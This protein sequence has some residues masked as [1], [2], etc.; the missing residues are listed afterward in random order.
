LRRLVTVVAIGVIGLVAGIFLGA[1]SSWMPEPVRSALIEP[2]S[3]GASTVNDQATDLIEGRYFREPNLERLDDASIRGMVEELRKRYRDRFTHYFDPEQAAAFNDALSG[4]FSGVGMTVGALQEEGFS[5]GLVFRGSPAERAG[6]EPGDVIVSVDGDKIGGEPIDAIVARIKGRE[7]TEVD[8]GIRVQGKGPAKTFTLQREEIRVPVVT[9]KV[10]RRG[11]REL[12]YV[13][14]TSFSEGSGYAL[15]RVL[16][17]VV[18]EGAE[19]IVLDLR[20]NGGGLLPEAIIAT[21]NFTE[22]EMQYRSIPGRLD[23]PPI[24]VLMDRSTASAAEILAAALRFYLDSPLVG[25]RSFGKGLF[26][27]VIPLSN[28]GSLDLSVGEF[29]TASGQSLAGGGLKPDTRVDDSRAGGSD[30]QLDRA[31]RILA[32]RIGQ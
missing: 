8:L 26:Q 19:G 18:D 11:G 31:F 20:G 23:L 17:R 28:G 6:L 21:S 7:G 2:I 13:R 14:F 4:T 22:G 10:E 30:R 5:V 1:N 32:N 16:R 12:G 29:V 25:T 27:Q 24:V 15:R 3:G 9:G